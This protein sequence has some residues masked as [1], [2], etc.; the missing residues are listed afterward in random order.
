MIVVLYIE[1]LILFVGKEFM[2]YKICEEMCV[3]FLIDL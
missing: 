1:K 2:E 3:L